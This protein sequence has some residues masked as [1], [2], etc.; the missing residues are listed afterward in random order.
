MRTPCRFLGSS[1]WPGLLYMAMELSWLWAV[2]TLAE[3]LIPSAGRPPLTW[4]ALVEPLAYAAACWAARRRRPLPAEAVLGAALLAVAL[5]GRAGPPDWSWGAPGW[6]RGSAAVLVGGF[7]WGRGRRL[8]GRRVDLS[9]MAAGFQ[10]GTIILMLT[11]FAASPLRRPAGMV[12]AAVMFFLFGLAGLG[13]ARV[14]ELDSSRGVSRGGGPPVLVMAAIGLALGLGLLIWKTVDRAFLET[15]VSP[16]AWLWDQFIL[17]LGWLASLLPA[18]GETVSPALPAPAPAVPDVDLERR[19]WDFRW[20]RRLGEVMFLGA[21]LTLVAAATIRNLGVLAQWL[22][23]KFGFDHA[24]RHEKLESGF[25]DDVRAGLRALARLAAWLFRRVWRPPG[26][27]SPAA[28]EAARIRKVYRRLLG[29]GA[30]RGRPRRP[31]QTPLEYLAGLRDLAPEAAEE[32][33]VITRAYL[34]VR[35]GPGAPTPGLGPRVEACWRGIRKIRRK[36][37]KRKDVSPDGR[38]AG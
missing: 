31:A 14:S 19:P 8:P 34:E 6:K 2:L 38:G 21:T 27:A 32:A 23:T 12:P 3:T 10:T 18:S 29:W 24:A 9:A 36:K 13:W 11:L 20:L 5:Y 28:G 33:E 25:V 4:L 26:A 16:I 37:E 22:Q 1:S 30:S 15:M 7:A 17:V 35:Y